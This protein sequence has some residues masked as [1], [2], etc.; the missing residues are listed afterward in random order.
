[1]SAIPSPSAPHRR[2]GRPRAAVRNRSLDIFR[3][4]NI[5]VFLLEL[6]V[7]GALVLRIIVDDRLI[8]RGKIIESGGEGVAFRS[9][10][11]FFREERDKSLG[12]VVALVALDKAVQVTDI[13][14]RIDLDIKK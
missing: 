12:R 7:G 10:H 14:Q 8:A 6:T 1:M 4:A 2:K 9:R 3:R 11:G 5:R 13:A